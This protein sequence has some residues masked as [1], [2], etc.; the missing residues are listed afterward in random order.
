MSDTTRQSGGFNMC[1]KTT[2]L[3]NC[4]LCTICANISKLF[5]TKAS[6]SHAQ[7]NSIQNIFS[8]STSTQRFVHKHFLLNLIIIWLS[9][10]CKQNRNFILNL[11][12]IYVIHANKMELPVMSVDSSTCTEQKL[13]CFNLFG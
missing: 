3:P 6:F 4:R 9:H 10:K 12:V 11:T 2:H 1:N 13:N 7:V 5:P 8:C